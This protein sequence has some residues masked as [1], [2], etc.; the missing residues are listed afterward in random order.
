MAHASKQKDLLVK[1]STELYC[2]GCHNVAEAKV[3][4]AH[5]PFPSRGLRES[6]HAPHGSTQKGLIKPVAHEPFAQ[7]RCGACH[8]V[9]ARIR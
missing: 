6:C 5:G 2:R 1:A 9:N 3:K 7:G 8:Q 4:R